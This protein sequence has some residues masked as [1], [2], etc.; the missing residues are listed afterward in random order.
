MRDFRERLGTVVPQRATVAAPQTAPGG[1]PARHT[2]PVGSVERPAPRQAG[3]TVPPLKPA[4][5]APSLDPN[6]L[7][8]IDPPPPCELIAGLMD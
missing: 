7:G 3:G 5:L 6:P 4:H 8:E 2:P 1:C